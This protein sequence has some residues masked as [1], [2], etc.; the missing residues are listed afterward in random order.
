MV[1]RGYWKLYQSSS[2][3][4]TDSTVSRLIERGLTK[5]LYRGMGS[6]G[7]PSDGDKVPM[8]WQQQKAVIT[9][10][11]QGK[12]RE[13]C[14]WN[15]ENCSC[16]K[17]L[18]SSCYGYTQKNTASTKTKMTSREEARENR[19]TSSLS[20]FLLSCQ[21]YLLAKPNL[22]P[23]EKIAFDV[24]CRDLF[25]EVQQGREG[26]RVDLERQTECNWHRHLVL[27]K[28]AVLVSEKTLELIIYYYCFTPQTITVY[29]SFHIQIIHLLVGDLLDS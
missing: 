6:I 20:C 4:V 18:H 28:L 29:K 5:G 16:M 8:N 25:P 17:G 21:C 23:K 11:L 14:F 9:L 7:D 15:P 3:Q 24:F 1:Q 26:Q 19:H 2:S 10:D 12:G 27:G 22:K 13:Q